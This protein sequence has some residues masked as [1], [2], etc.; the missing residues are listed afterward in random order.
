MRRNGSLVKA[1]D[2]CRTECCDTPPTDCCPNLC[3]K[4]FE[5]CVS[6]FSSTNTQTESRTFITPV[7]PPPC[8]FRSTS[9]VVSV[10]LGA[11]QKIP[12]I[13]DADCRGA[14]GNLLVRTTSRSDANGIGADCAG[15]NSNTFGIDD[16]CVLVFLDRCPPVGETMDQNNSG[17][18]GTSPFSTDL[19]LYGDNNFTNTTTDSPGNSFTTIRLENGTNS[20]SVAPDGAGGLACR[21]SSRRVSSLQTIRRT[22]LTQ[23]DGSIINTIENNISTE[24]TVIERVFTI[25]PIKDCDDNPVTGC[26]GFIPTECTG[27]IDYVVGVPCPGQPAPRALFFKAG[28]VGCDTVRAGEFCYSVSDRGPFTRDGTSGIVSNLGIANRRRTCCDCIPD[29]ASTVIVPRP[30]WARARRIDG[31]LVTDPQIVGTTLATGQCCCRD[32]DIITISGV[33]QRENV[34]GIWRVWRLEPATISFRR[35]QPTN[36]PINFRITDEAGNF[37]TNY[38]AGTLTN[39][40]PMACEWTRLFPYAGGGGHYFDFNRPQD[41]FGRL[42]VVSEE[43]LP[44]PTDPDPTAGYRIV[45]FGVGVNC[46]GFTYGAEYERV[47]SFERFTSTYHVGIQQNPNGNPRCTGGCVTQP[48]SPFPPQTDIPQPFPRGDIRNVIGG[49]G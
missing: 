6:V 31:V 49:G 30:C 18:F 42:A 21:T 29:C 1:N 34:T 39:T 27:P 5:V 45:N 46:Q 47:G 40:E 26:N 7:T 32:D 15:L 9:S 37:I 17:I 41:G 3:G 38:N 11:P 16:D 48:I 13:T 4:Q 10:L 20:S 25:K 14:V 23:P 22:R 24:E 44:C 28:V 33:V 12:A 8:D 2:A 43:V 19:V 36:I 35:N